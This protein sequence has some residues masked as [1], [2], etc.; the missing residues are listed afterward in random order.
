MSSKLDPQRNVPEGRYP[1]SG[2]SW[3]PARWLVASLIVIGT[4]LTLW[5][6]WGLLQVDRT[7]MSWATDSFSVVS[8]EQVKV[9]FRVSKPDNQAIRCDVQAQNAQFSIIGV[10][11]VTVAADAARDTEHIVNVSTI[12]RAV[13]ASVARCELKK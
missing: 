4:A 3:R 12:E 2:Q 6:G 9:T 5:I 1:A 13:T 7:K 10:S 11:S 8:N